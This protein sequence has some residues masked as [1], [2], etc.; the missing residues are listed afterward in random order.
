[1]SEVKFLNKDK[2]YQ[3]CTRCIMDTSDEDIMFDENGYCNHCSNVIAERETMLTGSL[4][5]PERILEN[6]I[7]KI[8]RKGKKSTYDCLVGLSG[9][10]DS[11]YVAWLCK[12]L[13]LR[14]LLLHVDNGWST[15]AAIKNIKNIVKRTGFDYV[16]Y[17]ID[18]EEFREI[19]LA[20]L[21]S[22]S[23]DLEFPTDI[24]IFATQNK[25]AKK[26][27]IKYI[28]SGCNLATESILP[29][30]WGYHVK[31]DLKY[32]KGIVRK[33]SSM[34]IKKV[35]VETILG[36]VYNKFI[37]GIRTVY[38]LNYTHYVSDN[39]KNVL[40][41]ELD[42]EEYEVKHHESLITGFWQS[43]IMPTKYNMDYRRATLSSKI[44]AGLK[45][46]QEA[47]QELET[48]APYDKSKADILK[49]YVTKK[50]EISEGE[51]DMYL[52]QPP[53]TYKNF[54]NNKKLIDKIFSFYLRFFKSFLVKDV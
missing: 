38:M 41:K 10:V 2:P 49:K 13:G 8:K 12:Q 37:K 47:L 4:M 28:I 54:P 23:V 5:L 22:S 15:E 34:P 50:F 32:Y 7:S 42:W 40:K 43:Y 11:S 20:F 44:C 19:Q 1:M 45:T 14:P 18:W 24:A 46:R 33:F 16:S 21:K 35:P 30:T 26:Y 3:I 51:M 48:N 9:G 52:N 36:E 31:R 6:I 27:N 17:V 39:V 53:K 25:I 29:L